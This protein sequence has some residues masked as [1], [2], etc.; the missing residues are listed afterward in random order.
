MM[1]WNPHHSPEARKQVTFAAT[2]VL[3]LLSAGSGNAAPKDTTPQDPE[4]TSGRDIYER[5]LNNRFRSFIQKTT[6][7]SMDRSGRRQESKL[8]MYWRDFK[9]SG[10]NTVL[11]KTLVRYSHPFDIRYSGYLVIQNANRANEQFVYLPDKRKISRVQLRGQAIFGTDFSYEDIIP[12]ELQDATYQRADDESY[13]GIP[14][15]VI[16]ATPTKLAQSQYSRFLV[17]V[18]KERYVVLRSRY[19]DDAEVEVKEFR[20][21]PSALLEFDGIWVPTRSKMRNHQQ[22]TETSLTI[23]DIEPNPIVKNSAFDLRRLESH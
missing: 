13:E 19:W 5:V 10:S 2:L 23:S 14:V 17:Y 18:D 20:A 1:P 9:V 11:S 8:L 21:V 15:Y 6:L 4:R 22:E 16:E 12:G 3:M 7:V